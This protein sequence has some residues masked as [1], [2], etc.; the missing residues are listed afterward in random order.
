MSHESAAL[1]WSH[2][3][4]WVEK[5]HAAGRVGLQG[6]R[7]NAE[8]PRSVNTVSPCSTS[9]R[10]SRAEFLSFPRVR[11]AVV[12]A[13]ERFVVRSVTG[14]SRSTRSGWNNRVLVSA[15][16]RLDLV[17]IAILAGPHCRKR[18]AQLGNQC[19]SRTGTPDRVGTN[20]VS[21]FLQNPLSKADFFLSGDIWQQYGITTT[22]C[23]G[24]VAVHRW[25]HHERLPP[26]GTD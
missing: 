12:L 9:K 13:P 25:A 22:K 8:L 26:L 19:P 15:T 24:P 20:P 1:S 11:T 2:F 23:F 16:D 21:R 4:V 10:R 17:D 14:R 5:P 7:S 18:A 6:M 3:G